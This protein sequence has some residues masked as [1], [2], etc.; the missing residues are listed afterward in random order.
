MSTA[1]GPQLTRVP[2]TW[3]LTTCPPTRWWRALRGSWLQGRGGTESFP[4]PA[5]GA[6]ERPQEQHLPPEPRGPRR[7]LRFG[8]LGP[9]FCL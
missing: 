9:S 5:P 8:L 2:K 3:V 4:G 6:P 1:P 7:T